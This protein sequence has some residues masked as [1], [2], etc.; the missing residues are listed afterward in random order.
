MTDFY[1]DKLVCWCLRETSCKIKNVSKLLRCDDSKTSSYAYMIRSSC[2]CVKS[3][4]FQW[5]LTTLIMLFILSFV[6]Q[7]ICHR[8]LLQSR[9]CTHI[10]QYAGL[11][12]TSVQYAQYYSTHYVS[13]FPDYTTWR[14]LLRYNNPTTFLVIVKSA[15]WHEGTFNIR[16]FTPK[17]WKV[18]LL[19]NWTC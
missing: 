4:W 17:S 7:L 9:W 15:K 1:Q 11:R 16:I 19:V 8:H 18:L 13:E 14:R 12:F 2:R 3:V 6:L 5:H 10:W